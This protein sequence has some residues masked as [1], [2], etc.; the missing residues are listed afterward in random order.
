MTTLADRIRG[1]LYG[2]AVGDALG[3]T[4]EFMTKEQIQARYGGGGLRDIVGGGW[5]GLRPG[6]WTDDTEMTLAVAEGVIAAPDNPVPR[7]GE[8]FLRWR[9]S[10]PP[11]IGATI[12]AAFHA[13]DRLQDW[14]QAAKEVD[15]LSGLTAGN[16]ALMRTLPL[17]FAYSNALKLYTQCMEVARMTHW[18]P[19]AGLTCFVYCLTVQGLCRWL[20]FAEAY[21]KALVALWNILPPGE[22]KDTVSSHLVQKIG[23]VIDWP[24]ERLRPTGYTVDTLACALWCVANTDS[25]EEAVIKAVNLG[26]DADTVGAVTGGL[27]GVMYGFDTIPVRW[28][29]VFDAKQ[30]ERLDNTVTGLIKLS[31]N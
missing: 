4:L 6:E 5:L 25:F 26:G 24:E 10:N 17:A 28:R 29:D 19:E 2:V 18:D 20:S 8:G 3:A 15:E 1:G 13:Y 23:D 31:K 30:R 27:A 16:G 21:K 14:Y 12:R 22:K 7:I 11:D 9:D